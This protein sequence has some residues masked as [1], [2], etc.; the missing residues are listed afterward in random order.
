[1]RLLLL[2]NNPAVSRL[3]RLSVEKVG[4]HLDEY[5]DYALVPLQKFDLILVDN[6]TYHESEFKVLCEQS[7]CG[8]SIYIGQRG[9]AKPESTNVL[10]EKP[11]LPTDFLGLL[12]KVKNVLSS[13]NVGPKQE[14]IDLSDES[15]SQEEPIKTFDIDSLE[16][17]PL[18]LES[19]EFEEDEYKHTIEEES[20]ESLSLDDLSEELTILDV[21]NEMTFESDDA[22]N[23][24]VSLPTFELETD[25][26]DGLELSFSPSV[27][28]KNLEEEMSASILD[29]DDINEVKLLLDEDEEP[30]LLDEEVKLSEEM[31]L[32]DDPLLDF[33]EHLSLEKDEEPM[34]LV[35]EEEEVLENET[36]VA[37]DEIEDLEEESVVEDEPVVL[38]EVV[39]SIT[40]LV[41]VAI[42]ETQKMPEIKEMIFDSLDA[43]NENAIKRAFGEEVEDEVIIP[44]KATPE[45]VLA[46]K[47]EVEET[48]THSLSQ[49]MQSEHLHEALK[50]MRINVAI[51]F[52]E[53]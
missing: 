38:P 36:L 49:L 21:P 33:A 7:E 44:L 42:E 43:L 24:D 18:D 50:G 35:L 46:L 20:D 23:E 28:E 47:N 48:I 27:E 40:P 6:D 25:E 16:S 10:L 8:Y 19:L 17:L 12:E 1:M 37:F 39:A 4:Y 30:L 51:T 9:H 5:N 31:T 34:S 15:S 45:E 26:N 52:E 2:N 14:M 11:F 13:F 32:E 53:V 3:I 22:E 41:D 29:K